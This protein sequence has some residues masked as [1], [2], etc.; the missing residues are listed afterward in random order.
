MTRDRLSAYAITLICL[1]IV[2]IQH[3]IVIE[4]CPANDPYY[5]EW[6]LYLL[7][8]HLSWLL[9]LLCNQ[10]RVQAVQ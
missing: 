3:H 7:K 10:A 1:A 8:C 4:I 6:L 5:T 2:L 9:I